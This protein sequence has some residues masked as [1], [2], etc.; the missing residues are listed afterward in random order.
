[1][2]DFS[3]EQLMEKINEAISLTDLRKL[4]EQL[5]ENYE[6]FVPNYSEDVI[7]QVDVI[8]KVHD[9]FI[10]RT[11][12]LSESIL[13]SD[14][15]M[16]PPP[17]SYDFVLFGSGGRMEQTPWSDQ[18]NGIIYDRTDGL[19]KKEVDLYFIQLS[20][21]IV[22][23]LE[24]MGYPPCDGDVVST[25][26]KWRRTVDDWISMMDQWLEDPQFE[27][28]RHLLITTDM[29]CIYGEGLLTERLKNNL[30]TYVKKNPSIIGNMLKNTLRHKMLLGI[31]GHLIKEQYGEKTGGVD[32]KY[33]AYIPM[34]NG[35]RLLSIKAGIRTSSTLERIR[36][37]KDEKIISEALA[38]EWLQAFIY[39][40]K[41][42]MKTYS[43]MEDNHFMSN[44]ILKASE[45]TKEVVQELKIN[46][47][48][49]KDMQR[50]IEKHVD[51]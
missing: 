17:V 21:L 13:E 12:S 40:L 39:F 24:M 5:H 43:K 1:M 32:I 35:I 23:G 11:I 30:F 18:D 3:W 15:G 26:S 10:Q 38:N 34:V 16:G 9:L 33:G 42:R 45:L 31:F 36:K 37:L 14:K 25:E 47:R 2:S 4:R 41:L 20:Q 29:R 6:Q 50:Y 49:G 46:L 51:K 44:G 48:I 27:T 8:N 7:K 22:E 19:N 28:M